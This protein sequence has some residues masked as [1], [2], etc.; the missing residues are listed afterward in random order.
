MLCHS[1]VWTRGRRERNDMEVGLW[2]VIPFHLL[3]RLGLSEQLPLT[4][5]KCTLTLR[6]PTSSL[7]FGMRLGHFLFGEEKSYLWC[8]RNFGPFVCEFLLRWISDFMSK[9]VLLP[10]ENCCFC[11]PTLHI[12][13]RIS[14]GQKMLIVLW[15]WFQLEARI[16]NS[17]YLLTGIVNILWPN[18]PWNWLVQCI[19]TYS[20]RTN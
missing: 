1:C 16:L 12:T 9:V 5:G 15:A 20:T 14:N 17:I 2:I 6:S 7:G 4:Y 13:K 18:R 8:S 10:S 11:L 19:V 3:F